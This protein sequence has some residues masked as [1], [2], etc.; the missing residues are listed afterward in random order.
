MQRNKDSFEKADTNF[1]GK[2]AESFFISDVD[3]IQLGET[4]DELKAANSSGNLEYRFTSFYF[5][6]L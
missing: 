6:N 5:N 4:D 3:K 1:Q 2:Y